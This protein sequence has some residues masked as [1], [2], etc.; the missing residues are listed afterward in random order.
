MKLA[1]VLTALAAL[2]VVG[3]SAAAQQPDLSFHI[4]SPPWRAGLGD[5]ADI[6]APIPVPAAT[7]IPEGFSYYLRLDFAYGMNASEPSFSEVGRLY[8]S[9]GAAPYTA[10]GS[11]FGFAGSGFSSVV[12]RTEDTLSG[13]LGFGAYL[14][15]ML[16]SDV[17]LEFRSDRTTTVNGTYSYTGAGPT[18]VNGSMQDTFKT[19]STV[20][21]LNAYLDLL[22]R[23]GFSPYVGAG[24]GFS[25]NQFGRNYTNTETGGATPQ[26]VG[27]SASANNVSLAAAL[28]GGVTFAFDHR[29]AIDL[30]YRALYLQGGSGSLT[31]GG[32]APAQRSQASL[33]DSW[34]HQVRVGLR[35]NIW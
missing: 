1:Q 20:A 35:F 18:T 27:G 26:I 17:T 8:G 3:T 19:R 9:G 5:V 34:E 16:R 29:W 21:L 28:M 12:S 30:N 31:V 23:G 4:P 11:P 22:P 24:I 2:A 15:P 6:P 14:T 7:P 13:G 32:L 25:Y 33:G 10:V